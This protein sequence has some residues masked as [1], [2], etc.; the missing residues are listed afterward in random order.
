[1]PSF[2]NFGQAIGQPL[3]LY[4]RIA[5]TVRD[6]VVSSRPSIELRAMAP[7]LR[8]A[9]EMFVQ[10]WQSG[11]F[12]LAGHAVTVGH[13]SP[14][15]IHD[16]PLPW[17]EA[18]YGFGWLRH[19]GLQATSGGD[20]PVVGLVVAWLAS[21]VSASP[22][23][24]RGDVVARRVMAWLAHADV[25]LQTS[26]PRTYDS[27]LSALMRD[28]RLLQAQWR[29]M[30]DKHAR[31]LALIALAEAGLCMSD[32]ESVRE[33]AEAG[34]R[35]ELQDRPSSALALWRSP[36]QLAPLALDLETLR[37][38]YLMQSVVVPPVVPLTL[39]AI[40]DVMAGLMLG[41]GTLAQLGAS[42]VQTDAR[43]DL[44]MA[45]RHMG[46][47]TAGSLHHVGA[48]FGRLVLGETSVVMDVAAPLSSADG[49]AVEMSSGNAPLL[50]HDGLDA[51]PGALLRG[52]IFF[53]DPAPTQHGEGLLL[54]LQPA[55]NTTFDGSRPDRVQI[56]A[57]HSGLA[58]YGFA[59]RRRLT[60][61]EHGARLC[62]IDELRPLVSRQG[63]APAAYAI[64]FLLHPSVKVALSALPDHLD[65]TLR[66]GQQWLFQASGCAL[67]VEGAVFR[68]GL[69][70]APTMQI[71]VPGDTG[72]NRTVAWQFSRLGLASHTAP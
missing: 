66:D 34:L 21:P 32:G 6:T 51:A 42:R 59:H 49:L 69:R 62:G 27:V 70:T 71:L 20:A 28:I 39:R 43:L 61:D 65:L 37:Q 25:L 63:I 53:F 17:R 24:R 2:P 31:L 60:L 9:D 56:D 50:V 33:A 5:E 8:A 23:A 4:D 18:L 7:S 44:A 12:P 22:I 10:E 46:A 64:R 48:G 54:G 68:D 55:H 72:A 52:T 38:L 30:P 15:D 67:S 14:F 11:T 40:A 29:A 26:S 47:E 41:D 19:V 16:A 57:T 36:G 45:L 58:R 13:A 1:V 3:R 35:D